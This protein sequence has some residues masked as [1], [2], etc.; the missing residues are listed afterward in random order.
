MNL[1]GADDLFVGDREANGMK[2]EGPGLR[3]ADPTM[4]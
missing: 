1:L 2:D 3:S 4:E